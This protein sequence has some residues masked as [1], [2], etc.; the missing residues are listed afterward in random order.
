MSKSLDFQTNMV[1]SQDITVSTA[2]EEIY[3]TSSSELLYTKITYFHTPFY[4]WL[5]FWLISIF[6]ISRLF[7]EFIIFLRKK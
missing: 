1:W 2:L 7:L 3:A 6:I 5:I 4:L